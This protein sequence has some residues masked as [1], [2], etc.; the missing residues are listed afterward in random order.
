MIE[1]TKFDGERCYLNPHQ[2]EC[3]E[4]NPDTTISLISGKKILVKEDVQEINVR[5]V[6]YYR[7]IG[8]AQA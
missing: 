5:I 1:I 8:T 6:H 7:K 2:I 3:I 4:K